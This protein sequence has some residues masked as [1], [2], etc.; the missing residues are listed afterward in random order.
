MMDDL[1]R[2]PAAASAASSRTNGPPPG[3][4]L[5]PSDLETQEP[6]PLGPDDVRPGPLIGPDEPLVGRLHRSDGL[7]GGHSTPWARRS[8]DGGSHLED[9]LGRLPSADSLEIHA[10]HDLRLIVEFLDDLQSIGIRVHAPRL[11]GF[12]L[13]GHVRVLGPGSAGGGCVSHYEPATT[14]K[15]AAD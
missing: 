5:I 10:S 13:E 9:R 15:T 2:T 3:L 8:L 14:R 1:G 7:L 12:D 11:D 4:R 6:S